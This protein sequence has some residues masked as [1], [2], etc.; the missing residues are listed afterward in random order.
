MCR[1]GNQFKLFHEFTRWET[2]QQ[3]NVRSRFG[4]GESGITGR[5]VSQR[6]VCTRC[7][8]EQIRCMEVDV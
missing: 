6:R 8:Y 5:Y 3:G 2:F 4:D 1:L 7:G